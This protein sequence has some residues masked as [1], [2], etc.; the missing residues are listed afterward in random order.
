MIAR[1]LVTISN[2]KWADEMDYTIG[3]MTQGE[4]TDD[5]LGIAVHPGAWPL[6]RL[7]V[8]LVLESYERDPQATLARLA[9]VAA[10]GDEPFQIPP[11]LLVAE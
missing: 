4:A 11:E 8:E 7:G 10:R 1:G 3:V 2:A 5:V 6:L 9:N